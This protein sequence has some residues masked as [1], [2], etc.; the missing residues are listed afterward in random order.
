MKELQLTF[1]TGP[2]DRMEALHTGEVTPDGISLKGTQI[3]SPR[4]LFDRAVNDRAFDIAE[5]SSSEHI[6]M[7]CAG[8]NPFVAIPVFPSKVFR[9][10]FITINTNAGIR[11]PAD[12][13]G[14]RIGLPLYTQTAAIWCR[15]LLQDDYGVDLSDVTWVEGA[16]P[17]PGSHGN[18]DPPPLLKPVKITQNTA[19]Y[20]LSDLLAT[21]EIDALIGAQLPTT[22]N[23]GNVVRLFPNFR[24]IERDYYSRTQ[25]HPIMHLLLIKRDIYD[26]NPWI[27]K[28]LYDA[29]TAAKD[30]AWAKLTYS[31]AQKIMLPWVFAE[32]TETQMLFGADPW[33]YGL[34]A[35][36]N[37][38]E[39]LIRHMHDQ[40]MIAHRPTIEELF[41]PVDR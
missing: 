15:G 14:K 39:A 5:M 21:G 35:N 19:P 33:P 2:Y 1:A 24:D 20:S 13:A 30:A 41:V 6:A 4:E 40:H 34:D 8:T 22:L 7:Y 18:P 36:R 16:V 3:Q 29:C 32:I 37:T 11:T 25:I 31:G 26:A 10:G 17:T 9:H 38:L 28:S 27:A 23:T 12:L